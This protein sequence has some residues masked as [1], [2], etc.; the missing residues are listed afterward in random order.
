MKK[1]AKTRT[2]PAR[3]AAVAAVVADSGTPEGAAA[4][5]QLKLKDLVARVAEGAEVKKKVARD[6]VGHALAE[7]GAALSQGH[8]LNLP[9]LGKARVARSR[10]KD[11]AEII[12]VRLRRGGAKGGRPDES[13]AEA[14]D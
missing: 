10:D 11:G 8:G 2:A 5:P 9:P 14:E 3:K 1:P 7:I 4:V 12:T 13:L 6:V